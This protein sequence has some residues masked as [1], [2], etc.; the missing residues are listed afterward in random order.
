MV[1]YGRRRCGKSRLLREVLPRGGAVYFVADDR[2]SALQRASLA[3]ALETVVAGFGRARH[4]SWDDLLD[5]AWERVP[6]GSVLALDEFPALVS[7]AP[8]LASLL[9]KRI[10]AGGALGIVLCGSSQRM[11]QGLVL[12][13]TAPLYGRASEILRIG[14][15]DAGWIQAALRLRDP[16][17]AIEAFAVWG[18]V[19]RYW[20]LAAA[21]PDLRSGVRDHVL[22]PLGV[23]HDEPARLLLDDLR[24][25]TQAGSILSLAGQGCHRVSEIAA[26][27]G[28]PASSLARPVQRLVELGLLRRDVPF[29]VP[30]RDAKRTLYRVADPFLR[31]WFRFV[32][33]N[34]SRLEARQIEPVT[35][36]VL[37]ELP[38][39]VAGVW[40]ELARDS[41][42]RLEIGG[43]RWRPAARWW[44]AGLG[45][46]PL[47]IDVVAESEDGTAVLVGE[48]EWSGTDRAGRLAAALRGG[49]ERL[50]ARAGRPAVLALWLARR[51]ARAPEGVIVLTPREVLAALR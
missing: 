10:D 47:E 48:A 25:T 9:Q 33:P 40:E 23:L 27:L 43:R 39:H 19:P 29:G 17:R 46:T 18:G 30:A 41:V 14:P 12:E 26:R 7:A 42:A 20:E 38:Q 51:P 49:A 37:R 24:D 3:A 32:E 36:A 11:M 2:E 50:P 5:D 31:F 34:R 22:S 15:L 35:A 13:R 1:V 4:A 45:R 8:E 21:A 16:R 28:K 44:G 6:A